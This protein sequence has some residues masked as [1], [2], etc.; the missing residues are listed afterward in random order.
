V[1]TDDAMLNGTNVDDGASGHSF[2]VSTSTFSTASPNIPNGA[3]S[4]PD[5]GPINASTTFSA[6]LSSLTTN[7]VLSGGAP[8]TM[9]AITPG[10]TYYYAAWSEVNGM[11]HPGT[12]LSFT[13][14]PAPYVMTDAATG[15]TSAGATVNGKNGPVDADDTSFWVG[16]TSPAPFVSSTNPASELP[17]GWYGV[18]SLTQ[19]VNGSF[20]Y[21]YSNLTPGTEYYFVAWSEIGGI[22]YPGEVLHFTTPALG[23]DDTLSALGVSGG[24]LT[25]DFDPGI[26][27]YTVL[28]PH[29][30]TTIPTVT[31]TTTDASATDT[32]T[33]ATSTTGTA[34]VAVV[35]QNGSSTQHYTVT[36]SLAPATTTL[37][38]VVVLVDNSRGGV[39]TSSDFTVNIVAGHPSIT[40]FSGSALGTDVTMDPGTFLGVNV[41]L[42][43]NYTAG[44][45]GN[46]SGVSGVAGDSADC[47][48]KETYNKTTYFSS[49]SSYAHGGGQVLGASITGDELLQQQI[50]AL[51]AQLLA[52]LQQYVTML[53][54][55]TTH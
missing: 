9:P 53:H 43:P 41:S 14:S 32:V 45:M 51:Q 52:L 55:H 48:I 23:G 50:A 6:S 24:I 34:I 37:L 26:T 42:L 22:W 13:T 47:T 35:A 49:G 30:A 28:L 12:V 21:S 27:S 4:T 46:C 31:A 3:Y 25:P 38:H 16:T 11:W 2:W 18:D 54:S 15:V 40:T 7:A 19:P 8:G 10:T 5:F 44:S 20:G 1:I 29:N 33:Q 39:A 17:S 36:F